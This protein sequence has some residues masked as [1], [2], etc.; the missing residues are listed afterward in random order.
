MKL[1]SWIYLLRIDRERSLAF[2]VCAVADLH[3]ARRILIERS[4]HSTALL[5]VKLDILKLR[6]DT[7]ATRHDARYAHKLVELR[8]TQVAQGDGER[9]L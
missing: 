4:K 1:Y 9:D 2:T 6:E 5:A 8:A 3:L 7:A